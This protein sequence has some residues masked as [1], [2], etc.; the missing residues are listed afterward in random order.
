MNDNTEQVKEIYKHLYEA[1]EG[2]SS[3]IVLTEV[4]IEV[5]YVMR[6]VYARQKED[7]LK[8][9]HYIFDSPLF[10]DEETVNRKALEAFS[11]ITVDWVD[12]IIR[13][14]AEE[15]HAEVI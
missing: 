7:V 12:I 3:L 13:L 10:F 9:L 14:K 4:I 1:Q 6:K 8:A 2:K 15:R 5:E 11:E